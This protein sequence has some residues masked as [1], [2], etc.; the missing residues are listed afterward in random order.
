MKN[1]IPLFMLTLL[2]SCNPNMRRST[3]VNNE[4]VA[5]QYKSGLKVQRGTVAIIDKAGTEPLVDEANK[6]L[7]STR[8]SS[9]SKSVII[10]VD[11]E[12]VYRY[13]ETK[14]N[15][16]GTFTKKVIHEM[17]NPEQE[18][19]NILNSR[20]GMLTGDMLV[21]KG[22]NFDEFENDR[23]FYNSVIDN[24]ASFNLH[25]S[26]CEF[27]SRISAETTVKFMDSDDQVIKTLSNETSVCG[28]KYSLK[29]IK[30]INLKSILLC[31]DIEG[32]ETCSMNEDMSWL[33]SD[34]Q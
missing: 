26:L 6:K 13:V 14:N 12:I 30:E 31:S 24:T 23:Y 1:L 19:K 32:E 7:V 21:V 11:G 22:T 8:V 34:I 10:H 18:L 3:I 33:T 2:V 5:D 16:S 29:Q 27:T 28:Q 20:H 9:R 25:R 15:V 17:M 4:G